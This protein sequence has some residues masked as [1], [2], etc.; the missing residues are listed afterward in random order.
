MLDSLTCADILVAGIPCFSPT[1]LVVELQQELLL[2]IPIRPVSTKDIRSCAN[3]GG[4]RGICA[5]SC[6]VS[7]VAV[8]VGLGINLAAPSSDSELD[9]TPS[10]ENDFTL[11][12]AIYL[13]VTKVHE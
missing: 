9:S 2:L 12:I 10:K 13:L 1:E 3:F 5:D 6:A 8:P 4:Y 7:I 11:T